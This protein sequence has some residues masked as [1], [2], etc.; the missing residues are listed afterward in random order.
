M[1]STKSSSGISRRNVLIGGAS[2]V[3]G[4][5]LLS[6]IPL[7]AAFG[8]SALS[9]ELIHTASNAITQ[10]IQDRVIYDPFCQEHG[11]THTGVSL[12][13]SG[14]IPRM[15]AEKDDPVI[16]LYM[17][18][19]NREAYAA[20][21][22]LLRPIADSEAVR[23]MPERTKGP[24]NLWVQMNTSLEGFMYK[25]SKM[26]R[27]TSFDDLFRPDIINHVAIPRLESSFGTSFA[28]LLARHF[29]GGVTNMDPAFEKL[30]E[31]VAAGAPVPNSP[32]DIPPV[33]D[34][35]DIWIMWYN[36]AF[37]KQLRSQGIDVQFAALPNNVPSF[38]S[39]ATIAKNSRN[40]QLAEACIDY[41]LR[42]DVQVQL[43]EELGWYPSNPEAVARL[44]PESLEGLPS[45][46]ELKAWAIDF[47]G[48]QIQ[49]EFGGWL[50]RWDR[51]YVR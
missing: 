51:Q 39:T 14:Q 24:D 13:A 42:P 19:G 29:G 10:A 27:P 44:T 31:L 2:S 43:F 37:A 35:D 9:G 34:R 6:G 36:H 47:D 8:Q 32:G 25:A 17:F 12:G 45:A 28:I 5:A 7:Q 16:D 21:L 48:A 1:K 49:E 22:D 33:M 20:K 15:I 3:A 38:G 41:M 18:S 46:E 4:G 23:A 40:P 50:E 11:V 26:D 30:G